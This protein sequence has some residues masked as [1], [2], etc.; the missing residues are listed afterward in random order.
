MFNLEQSIAAWRQQ[1]LAA[2]IKSPAPLEELESHLRQEI[3][4]Q[5]RAGT[6]EHDAFEIAA[7]QIGE[8]GGIKAEFGKIDADHASRPLAWLAWG[9]FAISFF[10]PACNQLWGWQCA[11][12][13]MAILW[14]N[15]AGFIWRR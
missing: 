4:R 2:G 8:A 7:Q 13:S 6:N 1:M 10:L 11:R 15:G 3:E 9:S 12:L 5:M 14:G